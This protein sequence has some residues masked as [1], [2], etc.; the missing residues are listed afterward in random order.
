VGYSYDTQDQLTQETST[1]NANYTHNFAYDAAG[2]PT[3]FKGASQSF[4]D[5]NQRTADTCDGNGNA[6]T[7]KGSTCSFDVE[8]RLTAYGSALTCAYRGDGLRA[9]KQPGGGSKTYFLYDGTAVVCELDSSGNVAA[10]STE[11]PDGRT[12]PTDGRARCV[13]GERRK[14]R[15][16]RLGPRG[17]RPSCTRRGAPSGWRP[18]P[19]PC[20]RRA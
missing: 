5:N 2:N 1:R 19:V 15:R 20:R 4:N 12:G 17:S 16:A 10:Y 7:Y 3:T 14:A 9:R 13:A 11:R 6:T 18:S 8:N